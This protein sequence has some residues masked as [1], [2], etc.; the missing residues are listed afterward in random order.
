MQKHKG[1]AYQGREY[2]GFGAGSALPAGRSGNS[3]L[4][5]DP[6]WMGASTAC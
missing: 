5:H 4:R 1:K 3:S 6:S 2:R